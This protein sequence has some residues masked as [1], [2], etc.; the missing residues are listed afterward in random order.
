MS[1]RK[2]ASI[3]KTPAASEP[4]SGADES[5]E[6]AAVKDD[7]V[8]VTPDLLAG[9]PDIF[10]GKKTE[11]GL[12]DEPQTPAAP[13]PLVVDEPPAV[14]EPIEPVEAS[15]TPASEPAAE[16]APESPAAPAPPFVDA[17]AYPSRPRRGGSSALG[18]VLVVIGIFALVI[19]LTGTDLTLYGWPLFII[20]PGLTL[21]VVGFVSVG[22]GATI[23]G[24]ILSV[25]GVVLAYCNSTSDWAFLAYGWSLVTPGGVGLGVYLQAL[26][27]HDQ[28]ALRTGRTLL[29]ISLMIFLI[30]FVVFES[31]LGISGRDYFGPIGKA[32]L[33]V[34]L[35]LVGVILLV[36]SVQ[37]S[38]RS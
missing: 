4:A 21:L 20:I 5:A 3:G 7:M 18:I 30:G 26:R 29:F 38:R 16:L 27:D 19:V 22:A 33:P 2:R 6:D 1:K 28:H 37:R 34:L 31:I 24:G 35:I 25:L 23:P 9:S 32:A 11:P 15:T 36:R 8:H 14:S 12:P 17:A 13:E 10:A